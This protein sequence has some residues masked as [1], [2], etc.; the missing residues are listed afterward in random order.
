MSRIPR[1]RS[2]VRSTTALGGSS[3]RGK[4]VPARGREDAHNNPLTHRPLRTDSPS[5]TLFFLYDALLTQTD[6][7]EALGLEESLSIRP[8]SAESYQFSNMAQGAAPSV[9]AYKTDPGA[10]LKCVEGYCVTLDAQQITALLQFLGDNYAE[11]HLNFVVDGTTVS[12]ATYIPHSTQTHTLFFY[13][14]L[15]D[16]ETLRTILS[17]P[18]T[19][20]PV[21]RPAILSG[22]QWDSKQ[23]VHYSY[24]FGSPG[25][26][27]GATAT[28]RGCLFKCSDAQLALLKEYETSYYRLVNV[29]VFDDSGRVV[30]ASCFVW[31]ASAESDQT[32]LSE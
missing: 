5:A 24:V 23:W 18:P 12:G 31:D 7:V 30:N 8:A 15:T 28:V 20:V 2:G 22:D 27:T 4:T 25:D 21:L 17:L 32:A 19:E 11:V 29:Q 9:V 14:T 6:L 13:G 3:R 1:A 10:P 16:P 26:A